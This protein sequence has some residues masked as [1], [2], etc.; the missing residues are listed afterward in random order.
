MQLTSV[1][2]QDPV[3]AGLIVCALESNSNTEVLRTS[4]EVRNDNVTFLRIVQ[5]SIG[6]FYSN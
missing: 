6:R 4:L 3:A 5:Y 2:C 1:V